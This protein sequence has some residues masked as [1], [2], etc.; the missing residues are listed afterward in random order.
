MNTGEQTRLGHSP[1]ALN[2]TEDRSGAR[3][4]GAVTPVATL[5]DLAA[6][7][8]L[9]YNADRS[10]VDAATLVLYM[11]LDGAVAVEAIPGSA[12]RWETHEATVAT[13]IDLTDTEIAMIERHIMVSVTHRI[14]PTS[15]VSRS[16]SRG[17]RCGQRRTSTRKVGGR[18]S[19]PD[20]S[21]PARPGGE[22]LQLDFRVGQRAARHPFYFRA[23]PA[24]RCVEPSEPM[25][26]S[27]RSD[28]F[29]TSAGVPLCA[30]AGG[31]I[32]W[33]TSERDRPTSSRRWSE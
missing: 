23:V 20:S 22:H 15:S 32:F 1:A 4:D 17:A 6:Y 29:R 24:R 11:I 3:Q 26:A 14:R 28:N 30:E 2:S 10:E 9:H 5:Q 33:V 21:D 27:A 8:W 31:H 19:D 16:R 12:K 7:Y 18:N 25:T 13:F